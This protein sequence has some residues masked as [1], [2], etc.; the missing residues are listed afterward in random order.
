MSGNHGA[1]QHAEH[2]R[3]ARRVRALESLLVEKGVLP[4]DLVDRVIGR[5][6]TDFVPRNGSTVVARAWADP[7]YRERLLADGPAAIAELG[8]GGALLTVVENTATVHNLLV[9]TL[10]S[11]YPSNFLG[12]PPVWYKSFAY[13][14]RA[15]LEPRAVLREFGLELDE[16]VEVRVWDSTS[17]LRYMVLPERPPG[18]EGRSEAALAALVA[19]DA[20]IGVAQADTPVPAA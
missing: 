11:C 19:R 5:Y 13:R 18:T 7:E 17:E 3:A 8:F 6:E 2:A 1:G 12:P 9:C 4:S 10:C 15:V 14:A 16:S 20:L